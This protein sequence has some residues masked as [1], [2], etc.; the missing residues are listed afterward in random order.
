LVP[1]SKAGSV[2]TVRV[3]SGN[4]RGQHESEAYLTKLKPPLESGLAYLLQNSVTTGASGRQYLCNVVPDR[5]RRR[6]TC[7]A[8]FFRSLGDLEHC[9][10]SHPPHL[11]I[12]HGA[13]EQAKVFGGDRSLRT[14][15]EVSC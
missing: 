15:H 11:V 8:G 9:S 13:I 12:F 5:R 2:M 7:G 4:L 10:E 14:W 6:V 3:S 1:T